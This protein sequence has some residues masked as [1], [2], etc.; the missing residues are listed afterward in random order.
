MLDMHGSYISIGSACNSKSKE[1]SYVL[2]AMGLDED[3]V[4][5][6]VRISMGRFN[7]EKDVDEII[8]YIFKFYTITVQ[9]I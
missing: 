2:S 5:S 7:A 6:A 4:D 9:I 3:R 1:Y 8:K